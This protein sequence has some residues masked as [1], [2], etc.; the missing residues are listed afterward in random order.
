MIDLA[1]GVVCLHA[2]KTDYHE[3]DVQGE[4]DSPK[5]IRYKKLMEDAIQPLY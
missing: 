4:D 2:W 5:N 3:V 1:L